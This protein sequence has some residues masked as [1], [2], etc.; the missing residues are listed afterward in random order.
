VKSSLVSLVVMRPEMTSYGEPE[1]GENH[2]DN[3]RCNEKINFLI[4]PD[5]VLQ[6]GTC[7]WTRVVSGVPQQEFKVQLVRCRVTAWCL[8]PSGERRPILFSFFP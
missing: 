7:A 5:L 3:Q 6:A 8:G 4:N 1:V 2:H